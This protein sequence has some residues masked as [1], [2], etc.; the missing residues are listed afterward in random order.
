MLAS[1]TCL[2][3]RALVP[4]LTRAHDA[5]HCQMPYPFAMWLVLGT[6][7]FTPAATS[8]PLYKYLVDVGRGEVPHRAGDRGRDERSW[9]H[10]TQGV[11]LVAQ[12]TEG[13]RGRRSRWDAETNQGRRIT[14]ECA[15]ALTTSHHI[16][17]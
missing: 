1:G 16:L 6:L 3:M 9:G 7:V 8:L 14:F 2:W 5:T 15:H 17:L 13:C 11:Q 10:V 4:H 12:E